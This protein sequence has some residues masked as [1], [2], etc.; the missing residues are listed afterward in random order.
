MTAP[1]PKR[2]ALG[3]AKG[4]SALGYVLF[5]SMLCVGCMG[6][7][8]VS[9]LFG[10]LAIGARFGLSAGVVSA[11]VLSFVLLGRRTSRAQPCQVPR[12]DGA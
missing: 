10:G 9:G 12:A 5:G 1:S 6:L 7:P 8:V 3:A 2:I 4:L 11:V